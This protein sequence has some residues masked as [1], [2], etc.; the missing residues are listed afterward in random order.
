MAT[1]TSTNNQLKKNFKKKTNTYKDDIS[2]KEHGDDHIHMPSLGRSHL[3]HFA[4]ILKSQCPST[5]P[6]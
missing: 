2:E 5:C 4:E 6:T 1:T 3:A